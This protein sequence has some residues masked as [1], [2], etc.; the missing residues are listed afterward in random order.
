MA[1][2]YVAYYSSCNPYKYSL[3]VKTGSPQ[4]PPLSPFAVLSMEKLPCHALL[5]HAEVAGAYAIPP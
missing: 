4:R 2:A 5:V 1:P 3:A